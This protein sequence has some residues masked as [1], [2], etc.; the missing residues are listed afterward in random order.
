MLRLLIAKYLQEAQWLLLA[1]AGVLLLFPWLRIWT[2]S[3]FDL[4]AFAPV[5]DQLRTFERFAPIP[6]EQFLT[7]E[8][9]IG[10]TFSEPVV[11]LCILVWSIS[12]GSDVVSGELNR[13]SMEMLLSQP[14]SRGQLM[15]A[16]GLVSMVGLGVLVAATWAGVWLGIGT[17][18]VPVQVGGLWRVPFLNWDVPLPWVEP[19]LIMRPLADLVDSAAF[20]PASVNLLSFGFFVW[21]LAVLFSS[22]DHFRWRTIGCVLAVYV[23]QFLMFLLSRADGRFAWLKF[24]TF[25][26]AYEPDRIVQLS[27]RY[28]AQKWQ[29]VVQ[30]AQ[31]AAEQATVLGPIGYSLILLSLGGVLYAWSW[32]HFV[33]RDLPAPI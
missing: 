2:I 15:L 28:P 12:R 10:L 23:G 1:L 26:S 9:V 4:S 24:L 18:A 30:E 27:V 21:T 7:Y 6:L 33:R 13:G 31:G 16:H 25:F 14:I 5:I 19:R 20:L 29:V 32:L 17:N 22:L 8:G 11:V 3:Q